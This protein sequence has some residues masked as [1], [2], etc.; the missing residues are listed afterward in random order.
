MGGAAL[1][2]AY[3][4]IDL[5]FPVLSS[6]IH[7]NCEIQKLFTCKT[8]NVTE[9]NI[10][11]IQTARENQIPYTTDRITMQD[12]S[13]LRDSG[14]ELL[15]CAGYYYRVPVCSWF[16]MVNFHPS[17]LPNGRGSWPM[18]W[19]ILNQR[20]VGG[21]TAHKMD[22]DFDTGDILL[23]ECFPLTADE[24][25]QT[26]MEKVYARI[27]DMVHHLVQDLSTVLASAKPQ[28]NGIYERAPAESDWTITPEMKAEDADRILRAFY[29]YEC[30]YRNG[31]KRT[32]L[33]GGKLIFGDLP[34]QSYPVKGGYIQADKIR[35]LPH[36]E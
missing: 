15:I 14:C 22:A 20:T 27:P 16:P 6:F 25:H 31:K 17:D 33:I 7:E 19:M 11:V 30:V 12:L 24:T 36:A 26:Y 34:G 10:R 29:G 18:P 9:F 32:E 28:E 2:I 21:I 35:E 5:L 13:V 3:L 4:G 8:D 23:Q 1:K